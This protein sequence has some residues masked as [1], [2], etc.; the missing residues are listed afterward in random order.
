MLCVFDSQ[1]AFDTVPHGILMEKL[2]QLN[3]HPLILRWVH[4]YLHNREQHV[5]VNGATSNTISVISGVP[6]GSVLGP[7]LFLIYINDISSLQLSGNSKLPLYADDMLLYKTIS[8]SADY[9]E[10][11]CDIDKIYGWS[12]ANLMTFNASKCKC[13]VISRK[14]RKITQH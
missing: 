8:T 6:Q 2:R 13:M 7:L 5:V 14:K 9:N 4:S 1:K 12:T 10:F 3:P 11:Q